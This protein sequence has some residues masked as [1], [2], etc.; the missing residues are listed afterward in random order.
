MNLDQLSNTQTTDPFVK[1]D[2]L[3][4]F[5]LRTPDDTK[6]TGFKVILDGKEKTFKVKDNNIL[7][8][9]IEVEGYTG[10]IL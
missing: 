1:T 6:V 2:R 10:K 5:V 8:A 4:I 3:S 9:W 7:S